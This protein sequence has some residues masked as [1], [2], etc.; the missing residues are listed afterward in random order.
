MTITGISFS[1]QY[2]IIIY[3]VKDHF[4]EIIKTIVILKYLIINE[5]AH[6]KLI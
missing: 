1:Y 3:F 5:I 4:I 2:K 6:H